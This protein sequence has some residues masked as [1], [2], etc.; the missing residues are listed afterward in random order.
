MSRIDLLDDFD[1]SDNPFFDEYGEGEVVGKYFSSMEAEVAAARLRAEGIPCFL[2][3]HTVQ[4][5]MPHLQGVIRLHTRPADADLAREILGEAALDT[6]PSRPHRAFN[7]V[8]VILAIMIGVVL[9][10]ALVASKYVSL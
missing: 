5:I 6:V 4:S 8:M 10:A 1:F 9:A 7:F 2:A 3:N